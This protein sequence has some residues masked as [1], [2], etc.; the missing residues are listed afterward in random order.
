MKPDFDIS[1]LS[2][3]ECILLAEQLWDRA[4]NHPEAIPVPPDHV[5]EIKRRVE[6]IDSGAMAPGE[7]WEA[8]RFRLW[9]R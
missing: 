9:G 8:V 5:A 2:P 7:P 1:Q 6:A 4:R 3:A